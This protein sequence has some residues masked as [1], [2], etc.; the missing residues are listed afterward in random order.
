[1]TSYDDPL[2][3]LAR[4]TFA[5]YRRFDV[6]PELEPATLV[7]QEEVDELIEAAHDKEG[8]QRVAEEAADVIVTVIGLCDAAGVSVDEIIAQVYAVIKKNDAK[9]HETHQVNAAGKIARRTEA[10]SS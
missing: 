10:Q 4:S 9:T 6:Q 3:D 2:R 1:M 7:L 5:F 8:T